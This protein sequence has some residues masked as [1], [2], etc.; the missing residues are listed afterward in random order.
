MS[1]LAKLLHLDDGEFPALRAQIES[2]PLRVGVHTPLAPLPAGTPARAIAAMAEL[3]LADGSIDT[4]PLPLSD[5]SARLAD[6]FGAVESALG[7][8]ASN[9]ARTLIGVAYAEHNAWTEQYDWCGFVM[10][11]VGIWRQETVA[12][13]TTLAAAAAP[14]ERIESLVEVA[15]R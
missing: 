10:D 2:K 15:S 9:T 14:L 1:R 13:D 7:Q 12:M 8:L 5:W 6:D 3:H 4:L 11:E